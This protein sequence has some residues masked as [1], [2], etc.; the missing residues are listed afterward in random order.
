MRLVATLVLGLLLGAALP[1]RAATVTFDQ[2]AAPA[3]NTFVINLE[4]A[5]YTASGHPPLHH[6]GHRDPG[7]RRRHPARFGTGLGVAARVGNRC[8]VGTAELKSKHKRLIFPR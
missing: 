3:A 2:A 1:A 8:S 5:A 7:H 6:A 4:A